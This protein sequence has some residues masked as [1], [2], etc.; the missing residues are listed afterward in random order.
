MSAQ[1]LACTQDSIIDK[2][3]QKVVNSGPRYDLD[4]TDE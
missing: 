2:C 1:I 3:A 4:L